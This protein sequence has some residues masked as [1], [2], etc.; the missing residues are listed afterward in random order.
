MIISY[1][2]GFRKGGESVAQALEGGFGGGEESVEGGVSGFGEG[3][4]FD[5]DEVADLVVDF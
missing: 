5:D 4:V 3:G 1:L 2:F